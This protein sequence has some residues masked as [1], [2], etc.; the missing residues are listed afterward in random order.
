MPSAL[1]V[2]AVT[3]P[4]TSTLIDFVKSLEVGK[5]PESTY[6]PIVPLIALALKSPPALTIVFVVP[7]FRM[8][9]LYEYKSTFLPAVRLFEL[10]VVVVPITILLSLAS[11][12]ISLAAVT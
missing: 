3:V 9:P 1:N 11:T 7:A 5:I 8:L 10:S 12:M 4:S 6:P 2:F